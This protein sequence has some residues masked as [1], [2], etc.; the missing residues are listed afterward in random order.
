MTGERIGRGRVRDA[1]ATSSRVHRR[2]PRRSAVR[3]AAR[4]RAPPS[5]RS[6]PRCGRSS[7]SAM[8][9]AEESWRR[10][11]FR[12]RSRPRRSARRAVRPSRVAR[13]SPRSM[14]SCATVPSGKPRDRWSAVR[15]R[16]CR[17]R[18]VRGP[19]PPSPRASSTAWRRAGDKSMPRAFRP[20]I[21]IR[22][23]MEAGGRLRRAL[24]CL[25]RAPSALPNAQPDAVALQPEVGRVEIACRSRCA[26][27][28][29]PDAA[30]AAPECRSSL[31]HRALRRAQA[32]ARFRSGWFVSARRACATGPAKGAGATPRPRASPARSH[33]LGQSARA[34]PRSRPSRC[35]RR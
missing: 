30:G 7:A 21:R 20:A 4:S 2:R 22:R 23:A 31:R 26:T 9:E 35:T 33:G 3:G 12:A 1:S 19:Q 24:E 10:R 25:D 32:S 6:S 28:Y 27:A 16:W 17:R 8:A 29:G 14:Q 13:I 34:R 11:R 5:I 15:P 18:R